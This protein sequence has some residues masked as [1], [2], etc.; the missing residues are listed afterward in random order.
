MLTAWTKHITDE[1]EKEEFKRSIRSAKTVLDRLIRLL[2]QKEMELDRS[3][4]DIKTY[5]SPSWSH[6][7]A[8][9]NGERSS[10]H[11]TRR[12]IDLDQQETK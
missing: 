4:T 12:L 5:S 9:K 11:W 7:Q 1:E 2:D 3:E 8:H 6:E 10:L